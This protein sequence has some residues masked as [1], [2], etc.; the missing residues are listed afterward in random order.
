MYSPSTF[1]KHLDELNKYLGY[2][3]QLKKH[4]NKTVLNDWQVYGLIERYLH[5]AIES[6]FSLG[7]QII[8]GNNY[9]L[10]SDYKDII[11]VLYEN[12]VIPKK[13][14][15]ELEG[16]AGFRNILVH[17]YAKIDRNMV[18]KHLHQDLPKISKY[19]KCLAR[20]AKV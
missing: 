3:K 1:A 12:K 18:Y 19:A 2:L 11:L 9:R 5:L 6:A 8:S 20:F 15:K 17:G 16:M 13:L 7:E 14:A 10:P 4:S